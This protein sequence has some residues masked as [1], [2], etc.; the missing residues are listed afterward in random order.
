MTVLLAA[1]L[2][3]LGACVGSFLNVVVYRLPRGESLVSPGSRC[4]DCGDPIR[5]RDN[6]PV[7][8]WLALRG[9][10]RDCAAPISARYP[11]VEAGTAALFVGCALYF[12]PS[13]ELAPALVLCAALVAIT[14]IDLDRLI[15][16][17]AIVLPLTVA[18]LAY[19][20]AVAP[21]HLPGAALGSLGAGGFLFVVWFLYPGGMGFGDVKLGLMLGA[22]LGV[23][24]VP[25]LFGGFLVGALVGVGLI[26]RD[27]A[28]A[29]K[30]KVP[31]GPFLALGGVAALFAGAPIVDWYAGLL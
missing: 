24:V 7:V 6:V 17:D 25:A 22:F 13:A 4:P 10:C 16:P 12:G 28:A 2:G 31:F 26:A 29:R 14:G 8:G 1:I 23:A 15:I 27:G 21:G 20:L 11:L 9:R 30:R 18:A 3:V 5:A 19:W